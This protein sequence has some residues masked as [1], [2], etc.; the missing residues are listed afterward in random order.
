MEGINRIYEFFMVATETHIM[1]QFAA[2][3][4]MFGP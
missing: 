4:D 3:E 1:G 2:E